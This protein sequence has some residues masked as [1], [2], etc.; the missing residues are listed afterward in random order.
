MKVKSRSSVHIYMKPRDPPRLV[1]SYYKLTTHRLTLINT[2]PIEL[3]I[4]I[5]TKNRS[6]VSIVPKN[7]DH[8]CCF[9]VLSEK[10]SI[11][12]ND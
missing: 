11:I 8:K 5:F 3:V 4:L 10:K 6:F 12:I 1:E 7:N 2:R 9:I